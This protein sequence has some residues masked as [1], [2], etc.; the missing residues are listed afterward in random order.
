ME[1]LEQEDEDVTLKKGRGWKSH[2]SSPTNLLII[3]GIIIVIVLNGRIGSYEQD[4]G[5]FTGL[6][7]MLVGIFARLTDSAWK[8][9]SPKLITQSGWT[10]TTGNRL[11]VG[12]WYLYRMGDINAYGITISG[13]DGT[14]IAPVTSNNRV[15]RC[16][17]VTASGQPVNFAELPKEVQETI[18]K[19]HM[20][21]PYYF[22]MAAE[23][24]ALLQL[25]DVEKVSGLKQPTVEYLITQVKEQNRLITMLGEIVRGKF[26]TIQDVVASQSRIRMKIERGGFREAVKSAVME[27]HEGE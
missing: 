14:I 27:K 20:P 11:H 22:F 10:T 7:F 18:I 26:K 6:M 21:A 12:N 3:I 9:A 16:V 24:Q 2:L 19:Y 17:A 4:R 23:E 25:K 1:M 5:M 13:K 15:G 8:N